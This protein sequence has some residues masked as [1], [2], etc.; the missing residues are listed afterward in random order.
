MGETGMNVLKKTQI[1]HV[2]FTAGGTAGHANIDASEIKNI[3]GTLG[4]SQG[5]LARMLNCSVFKVQQ[6][7]KGGVT[8]VKGSDALLIRLALNVGLER[9]ADLVLC[10][11]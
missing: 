10:E 7:E 3:R 8:Q 2:I 11:M 9:Y 6:W 5:V 1:D 4:V